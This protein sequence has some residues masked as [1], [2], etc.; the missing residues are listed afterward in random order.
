MNAAQASIVM[1]QLHSALEEYR[2]AVNRS[3]VWRYPM[4]CAL[5]DFNL[6]GA[7]SF[8]SV[9]QPDE[10][11]D[12]VI[13]VGFKKE[14]SGA[15]YAAWCRWYAGTPH[16]PD[17]ILI[18][19][20][21]LVYMVA[22]PRYYDAGIEGSDLSAA[23]WRYVHA[24]TND[25]YDE[26]YMQI[27]DEAEHLPTTLSL[28]HGFFHEAAIFDLHEDNVMRDKHGTLIITDPVS[29]TKGK[30]KGEGTCGML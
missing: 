3:E 11:P 13:K 9:F 1:G 19:R 26:D 24:P 8:A 10:Y 27:Q 21:E 4:T 18:R 25:E 6:M 14:D 22:M 5:R 16:V 15:A 23:L 2:H 29:Y 17:I 12:Y 28:I 20:F 7:G 30:A